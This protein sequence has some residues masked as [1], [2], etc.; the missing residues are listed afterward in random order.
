MR[1]QIADNPASRPRRSSQRTAR[2]GR[3]RVAGPRLGDAAF[4]RHRN[5]ER[6][7]GPGFRRRGHGQRAQIKSDA[8][9]DGTTPADCP[10]PSLDFRRSWC[11]LFLLIETRFLGAACWFEQSINPVFPGRQLVYMGDWPVYCVR[12]QGDGCGGC[13]ANQGAKLLSLAKLGRDSLIREPLSIRLPASSHGRSS[14]PSCPLAVG[15]RSDI[16]AWDEILAAFDQYRSWPLERSR[17]PCG[18]PCV[19]SVGSDADA[20]G[21]Q[22]FPQA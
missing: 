18:A 11:S 4:R 21:P 15:S 13:P 3:N 1:Y 19:F 5:P 16:A 2:E 6:S 20:A 7:V 17:M 10:R 9:C 14:Q 8:H 22:A 12:G